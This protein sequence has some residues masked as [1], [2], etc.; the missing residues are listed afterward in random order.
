MFNI[1]IAGPIDD[2]NLQE[3]MEWRKTVHAWNPIKDNIFIYDPLR[4][5]TT[6]D[7]VTRTFTPNEI[8]MRDLADIDMSDLVLVNVPKVESA[9]PLWGTPS[10]VMYAWMQRIPVV[11]V[12]DHP[13]IE[14]HYWV[15]AMCVRILPDL[16]SA[17]N[18]IEDYWIDDNRE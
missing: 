17:L 9:K 2:D 11:L 7:I 16:N 1:Y 8:V 15:R 14:A 5:K 3:A 4:N 18:Y 6:D 13:R 12:T 10:E